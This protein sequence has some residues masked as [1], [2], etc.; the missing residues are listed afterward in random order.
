MSYE[1]NS[2]G[3]VAASHHEIIIHFYCDHFVI[4]LE[5][6]RLSVVVDHH[7]G[8][9]SHGGLGSTGGRGMRR[10]VEWLSTDEEYGLL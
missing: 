6:T 4:E 9:D 3:R 8:Q 5:Q 2:A 7:D 10:W 1:E